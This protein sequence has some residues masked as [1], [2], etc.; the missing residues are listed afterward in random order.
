MQGRT[1]EDA[2][3]LLSAYFHVVWMYAVLPDL[4]ADGEFPYR[5]SVYASRKTSILLEGNIF[6]YRR[7]DCT[8]EYIRHSWIPDDD[9][10]AHWSA[11]FMSE[12][13]RRE[14]QLASS[15]ANLSPV[16]AKTWPPS[17]CLGGGASGV[18]IA[19]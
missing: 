10:P 19:V 4:G 1:S 5:G 11:F 3:R 16:V 2:D 9:A 7:I 14:R 18:K 15:T 17:E 6:A 12:K 13:L 8:R